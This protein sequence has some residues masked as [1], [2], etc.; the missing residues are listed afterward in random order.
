MDIRHSTRSGDPQ[1]LEGQLITSATNLIFPMK[2]IYMKIFIA[3]SHPQCFTLMKYLN[4][5]MLFQ[6]IRHSPK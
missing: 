3:W 5:Y 4:R 6:R 2:K 1:R